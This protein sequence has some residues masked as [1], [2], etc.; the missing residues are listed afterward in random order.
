LVESQIVAQGME[1]GREGLKRV[2][3]RACEHRV[4]ANV[5]PDSHKNVV[6]SEI[7][8]EEA[9]VF[10]VVETAVDILRGAIHAT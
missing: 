10:E 8:N 9:H 4:G 1:G 5:C 6:L 7:V 2:G 3:S